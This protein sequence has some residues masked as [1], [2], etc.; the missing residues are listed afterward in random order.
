MSDVAVATRYCRHHGRV[1]REVG[2]DSLSSSRRRRLSRR[3]AAGL[4]AFGAGLALSL[5]VGRASG[6]SESDGGTLL[7]TTPLDWSVLDPAVS[8]P[9]TAA[10]WYATCATLTAFRD[11]P[12]PAGLTTQ[13]EAAAGPPV[14]SRDGRTY[15]FTV[16]RGLRFSDGS[17]LTAANFARALGR[18]RNP[19]M[20]SPGASI[21]SDVLWVSAR[22]LRLRI[23]LSKPSGDLR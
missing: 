14:I 18:V 20:G 13:P 2:A 9:A 11:A 4:G 1:H 16:R 3:V 15:D 17:P 12:A 21:F 5:G 22:G 7:A 10:I 6:G 23:E 8:R 19:A